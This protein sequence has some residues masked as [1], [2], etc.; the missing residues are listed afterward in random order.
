M[1]IAAF[2]ATWGKAYKYFPLKTTF[3]LAIVIFEL[4]SLICAVANSSTTLI[5]G[6]AIAGVGGAGIASGCYTILA[7]SAPPKQTAMLTGILGAVYAV[8]SVIGPLLGGV[9][10]DNLSWRWCFYINLPI[11]GTAAVLIFLFFKTPKL[12]KPQEAPLLEK[13]LQMDPLGTFILMAAIVCLIL[14]L[15][16]G[17]TTKSWGSADVIGVLVGFVLLL[18]VFIAD[19]IW[20]DDRAL[21]LGIGL[22]SIVSGATITMTSH[23]I[24]V[25]VLSGIFDTV[26][27]GLLYTLDKGTSSGAWIGYQALA[28]IGF[29]LGVQV[30]VIVGQASV[31]KADV[32]SITAMMIF[33]Q[34]VAGAA[35]V[36]TGQAVFANEL[37][38][39]APRYVPGVSPAAVVATGATALRSAFPAEDLPGLIRAY[40]TGLKD[41]YALAIALSGMA[42]LASLLFVL[43]AR[44]KLD[45]EKL[46]ALMGGA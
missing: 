29:G 36:S 18:A 20:M 17:G 30:P 28:G 11:G 31:A 19:Q 21:I 34:T 40:M 45:H 8:A 2:Q 25:L 1:T 44:A 4:G 14:A 43:F 16:W 22:M 6:R 35:L 15:Q 12:A 24:P 33:F 37:L 32:S 23:Y 46:A 10:T 39:S 5:V 41:T 3:L 27:A 7:F 9:F 26:G 13:I 38:R 42:F